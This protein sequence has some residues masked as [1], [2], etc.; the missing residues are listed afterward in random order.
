M[1]YRQYSFAVKLGDLQDALQSFEKALELAKILEDEAAE[2]A[3]SKAINDVNDRI[4]QGIINKSMYNN[5]LFIKDCQH[6]YTKYS[7]V[8]IIFQAF[9]FVC[10][11]KVVSASSLSG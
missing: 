3:I 4:A 2:N 9:H 6:C 11:H 7:I 8:T 5:Y 10:S 1:K